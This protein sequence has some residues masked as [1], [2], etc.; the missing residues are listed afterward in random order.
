MRD[1]TSGKVQFK[2][3]SWSHEPTPARE[4]TLSAY[5]FADMDRPPGRPT[6]WVPFVAIG[7]AIVAFIIALVLRR[8]SRN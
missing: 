2:T 6:N 5:G 7:V 8:M 4:F 1:S 3:E